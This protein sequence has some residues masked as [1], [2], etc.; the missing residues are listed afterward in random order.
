M[1]GCGGCPGVQGE[2][3]GRKEAAE[4]L[5][6]GWCWGGRGEQSCGTGSERL[7]GEGIMG[8][9]ETRNEELQIKK[10]HVTQQ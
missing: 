6:G 7:R 10:E 5:C 8:R 9:G 1:Q 2:G 4:D 3:G